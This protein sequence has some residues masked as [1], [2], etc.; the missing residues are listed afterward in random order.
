M[1]H[2]DQDT[3]V[4]LSTPGGFGGIAV[5]RLSG[6]YSLNIIHN[7][8]SK[9]GKI[10]PQKALLGNIRDDG[11]FLDTAVVTFHQ[12]PRSYTGED[13]VEISC[14][15]S[16]YIIDRIL[17]ACTKSGARLA[18]PGEFTK[19][20][21]LNGKM[22]LSQAEAVSELIYSRTRTAHHSAAAMLRGTTGLQIGSL[23]QTLINI[24][25]SLEL[26]LDFGEEEIDFL[27][28]E[29]VTKNIT[30]LNRQIDGFVESFEYGRMIMEGIRVAIIGPPNSGKSSLFNAFLQEERVI[31]SP[32]PGTTRDTIEES[33]KLEGYHFRL[34]DTAGLRETEDEVEHIGIDRAKRIALDADIVLFVIDNRAVESEYFRYLP[35]DKDR[36]IFIL[37]KADLFS[38]REIQRQTAYAQKSG[39]FLC[40]AK[41]RTGI[42][43]IATEILNRV[44][45]KIP[46]SEEVLITQKRHRDILVRSQHYLNNAINAIASSHPSEIIV[47][48][49]REALQTLDE[50]LGKTTNE[51]ILNLIFSE[52]CIGK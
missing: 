46:Q 10:A 8:F 9:A 13:V 28:K 39:T 20:A 15:G 6:T 7:I 4:A 17:E 48:D 34:I 32:H 40:S 29:T 41:Q 36:T 21:F 3:I 22:D 33:Y 1:N 24:I 35:E 45:S 19:R 18:D 37:N 12:A 27:P 2:T 5:I 38:A 43:E 23:R 25:A 14:H 16:P 30:Q 52:F 42:H 31:V 44:K 47:I 49:L 26:E 50:I 11:E 51:D